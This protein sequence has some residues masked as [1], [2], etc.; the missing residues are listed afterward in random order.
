MRQ[1]SGAPDAVLGVDSSTQSCKVEI[2]AAATGEVLGRGQAT[3]PPTTP[4]RS[5]QDPAA[6]WDALVAAGRDAIAAAG[7]ARVRAVAVAGQQHGMVVLDD[8]DEVIRPAK[9]WNDTESADEAAALADGR[10]EWWATAIGSVPVAAFT[11]TKLAWLANHEPGSFDRIATVLLPHDWLTW[12]LGGHKVTDRGDAS[13]TGYWSPAEGRW[14]PGLLSEAAP[15]R[16]PD[17]WARCLPDVLGPT[18]RAGVV[19]PDAAAALGLPGDVIVGPGTGDNMAAALGLGLQP[20]DVAISLGTSGTVFGVSPTP[21]AD[22]SGA[23]AGFADAN[24]RFLP[25]VCTLNATL[26]TEAVARL[27]GTSI[28]ELDTMASEEPAGASGLV[29]VPYF[30]GERTPNRPTATGTVTGIRTDVRRGQLARAAFEGVVCGLLDGL[31]ALRS[32][33]AGDERTDESERLMVIGGGARSTT[34]RRLIAD[35]TG[36][37]VAVPADDELV[38]LGACV[39]AAAVLRDED[40]TVVASAWDRGDATVIEPDP[41]VDATAIRAAYA[42][43]RDSESPS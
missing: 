35:L 19:H 11:I 1:A 37:T 30:A 14:R 36:R 2:R 26:V 13:G 25:L 15:R 17:S 34:Y 4:P 16:D 32:A 31:D 10:E 23:V 3:H 6:W 42:K 8:D 38:A 39:Q 41:D 7:D 43:A 27:L 22:A 20:G 18:E 9:L 33:R 5:E 40:P 12:R 29:L 21:T 24:G 28:I